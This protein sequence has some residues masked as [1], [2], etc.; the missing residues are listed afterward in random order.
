MNNVCS[1]NSTQWALWTL[2][3]C[4][5]YIRCNLLVILSVQLGGIKYILMVVQP[6]PPSALSSF[7]K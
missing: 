5:V 6:S 7:L 4:E 3:C 1:V 2:A